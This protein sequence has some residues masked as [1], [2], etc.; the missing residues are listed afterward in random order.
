MEAI[1][2]ERKRQR[3]S[4]NFLTQVFPTCVPS[5]QNNGYSKVKELR[6][7]P[8]SSLNTSMELL[9]DIKNFLSNFTIPFL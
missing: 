7:R 4:S 1:V 6:K 5:W 3:F 2:L 8:T 9:R